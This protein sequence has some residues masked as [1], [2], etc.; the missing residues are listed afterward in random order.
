MP[1][2][3]ETRCLQPSCK[4]LSSPTLWLPYVVGQSFAKTLKYKQVG[5]FFSSLRPFLFKKNCNKITFFYEFKW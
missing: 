1:H 3:D 4:A 5:R 2:G